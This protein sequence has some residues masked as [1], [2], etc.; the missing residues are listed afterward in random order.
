LTRT[1]KQRDNTYS[2][3]DVPVDTSSLCHKV[4]DD[5]AVKNVILDYIFQRS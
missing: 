1:D 2:C 5:M 3:L 4:H